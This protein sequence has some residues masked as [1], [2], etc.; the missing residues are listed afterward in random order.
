MAARKKV[1]IPSPEFVEAST[2]EL[3]GRKPQKRSLVKQA[4]LKS[5]ILASGRRMTVRQIYYQALVKRMWAKT[6]AAYGN[7]DYHLIQMRRNDY[8]S[9]DHFADHT[10]F[11]RKPLTFT[12]VKAALGF[13]QGEYRRDFWQHRD[14]RVEVWLEKD[15]L[16]GLAEDIT[17]PYDVPLMV[18]RGMASL[19]FLYNAARSIREVGKTTYVYCLYDHDKV[20]RNISKL[21]KERLSE[22][23]ASFYFTRLA[24]TRE[25]ITEYD[26][27]AKPP[28]RSVELDALPVDIFQDLILAAIKKHIK[29]PDWERSQ[30]KEDRDLKTLARLLKTPRRSK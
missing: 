29:K 21:I 15:A 5:I 16:A 4:N 26:L 23:G 20:G 1:F 3:K 27:P 11:E 25:Q 6:P 24:V 12:G 28:G 8:V 19:T 2:K 18:T 10:R 30:R 9:H 22:Y 13:W 14:V 17:W 7:I